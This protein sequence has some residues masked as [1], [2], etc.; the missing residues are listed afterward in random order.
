MS[1]KENLNGITEN[2]KSTP[3]SR[4]I[5]ALVTRAIEGDKDAL[6][7][8]CEKTARTVLFR[9]KFLVGNEM[10]AEDV[11]QEVMIRMCEG[12]KKLR[13]PKAFTTWL[14]GIIS[15]ESNRFHS[16]RI[17]NSEHLNIDDY[18]EEFQEGDEA[19][20]PHEYIEKT[21]TH[22]IV[23]SALEKLPMRQRQAVMFHY[24]NELNI[25]ETAEAMGVAKQNVSKYLALAKEK[26]RADL[27]KL[28]P[29]SDVATFAG[30]PIGLIIMG[31]L[32]DGAETF[33]PTN[34]NWFSETLLACG[35]CIAMVAGAAEAT[36]AVAATTGAGATATTATIAAKGLPA[37]VGVSSISIGAIAAGCTVIIAACAIVLT[38]IFGGG[39][40]V[41]EPTFEGAITFSSS[42]EQGYFEY[43]H[44][45]PRYAEVAID[46]SEGTATALYW[47]ITPYGT[48]TVL[49]EGDGNIATE[50]FEQM[51]RN[52]EFGAY[53]LHFRLMDEAGAV[54]RVSS[55]FYITAE[56]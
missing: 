52:Q 47:W 43:H 42:S 32:R 24:Y 49:Y 11:A 6:S 41:H 39:D 15:N 50:I 18:I 33:N 38:M 31:A 54:F 36:S 27:S 29:S 14:S 25:T 19:L 21:E 40:Y 30:A 26:L 7:L 16:K 48:E 56:G 1:E 35:E 5:E 22:E 12:I 44:V 37:A 34:T 13:S 20:I 3:A 28:M 51:L 9:T 10:D 4:E 2:E 55:N 45:N 17:K 46:L 8:L 53:M 23:L